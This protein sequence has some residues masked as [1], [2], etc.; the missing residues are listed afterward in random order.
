MAARS[1]TK[2]R[3]GR[4]AAGDD[5]AGAGWRARA[6]RYGPVLAW[7]C[8][9]LFASSGA[10]SATQTSRFVGP[11]LRWLLPDASGASLELAHAAVRKLAHLF[12]YALLALLAA[13]AFRA[14]SRAPLRR[15]AHACAL[16]LVAAVA[17]ADEF[18]Q[19]FVATRVG[20]PLDVALDVAGGACALL[21]LRRLRARA[22]RADGPAAQ[23]G[24]HEPATRDA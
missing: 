14:S 16:A 1:E 5:A 3:A 23:T 10:M 12:E 19:S 17:L 21:L 6:W 15:R 8:F 22:T 9:I 20:T 4:A 18:H 11:L 24:R 2:V 13:R 7:T